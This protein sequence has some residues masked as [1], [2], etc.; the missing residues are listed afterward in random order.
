MVN[1]TVEKP[2]DLPVVIQINI[3]KIRHIHCVPPDMI[4]P[5]SAASYLDHSYLKMH[6]FI[7]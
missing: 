6:N 2:G 4:Y 3:T 7:I 5:K 1:F